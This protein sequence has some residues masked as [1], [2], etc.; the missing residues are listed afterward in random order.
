MF[1]PQNLSAKLNAV[2]TEGPVGPLSWLHTNKKKGLG[3]YYSIGS[4]LDEEYKCSGL[5][6]I[7]IGLGI[8]TYQTYCASIY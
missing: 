8:E 3:M 4:F 6:M 1:K 2:P 5:V 7:S